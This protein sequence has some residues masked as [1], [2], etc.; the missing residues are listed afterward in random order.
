M[1][2]EANP[3]FSVTYFIKKNNQYVN[4]FLYKGWFLSITSNSSLSIVALA[5]NGKLDRDYALPVECI[6][7]L[8]IELTDKLST[9]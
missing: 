5:P 8:N 2:L 4:T 9:K 3:L 6:D 7:N 1:A